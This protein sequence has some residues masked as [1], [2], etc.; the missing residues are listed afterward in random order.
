MRYLIP[1]WKGK[2]L[3]QYSALDEDS[4]A[5]PETCVAKPLIYA[6]QPKYKSTELLSCHLALQGC[7]KLGF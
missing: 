3:S 7:R 1:H 5:P 6:Y 4:L 2:A